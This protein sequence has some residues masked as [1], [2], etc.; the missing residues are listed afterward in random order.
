MDHETILKWFQ[1]GDMD[2]AV[3]SNSAVTMHPKPLEIICFHC[4]QAVEKYL[5]GYLVFQSGEDPLKTHNLAELCVLCQE[6]ERSFGNLKVAC[7]KLTMYA[8]QTRYPD[9]IELE[10]IDMVYALRFANEIKSFA[11]LMELRGQLEEDP[12]A[13]NP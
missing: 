3:A 5:K 4:Q 8:V 2:L 12:H 9:G 13:P 10:E 11:P 6:Y 1:F 7:S